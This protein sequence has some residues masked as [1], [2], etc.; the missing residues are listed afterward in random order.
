MTVLFGYHA[1]H[2]QFSPRDLVD[3]AVAAE[4]AG[5][6][7]V[8]CSD[9][10]APWSR[11]QGHSG[12]AWSWLGAAMQATTS[13]PFGLITVP[14]G[15]RYHPAIVAQA[16]ATLTD[17][18]PDRFAWLAL[19][20][21]E[22]LN[23]AVVGQG[24]PSK[25]ERNER[26]RA[27]AE[28]LRGMFDGERVTR[29]GP[30]R[31]EKAELYTR[32]ANPVRLVAAALSPETAEWAA[33]WADGLLTACQSPRALEEIIAAFR[34]GG[35]E[36]KPVYLQV[37]VSWAESEEAARANAFDQWRSNAVDA[38]AAENLDTP[39][40]FEAETADVSAADMDKYVRISADP[41]RHVEWLRGDAG[42][43]VDAIY[44]H[45]VGRNQPAFIEMFGRQVLPA[46]RGA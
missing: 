36:A 3:H 33:S 42:M 38:Y 37:H 16:T 46:L 15:W 26:L 13:L 31:V 4:K 23:E 10:F 12:F 30:L 11:A 43:G 8:M 34:R 2:E 7:C 28:I 39:E 17:L 40:A 24:W 25:A 6:D 19:G 45:N 21:G 14:G 20:S 1:S 18:F 22:K 41:A 27:G 44:I 32:P 9:H 29:N 35:G 5:F